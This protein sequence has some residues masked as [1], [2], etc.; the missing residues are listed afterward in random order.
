MS[1]S[2]SIVVC[3]YNSAKRLP[4]TLRHLA[5]Q[6]V[7]ADIP[8][9]VVLIDNASTDDTVE[10]ARRC[11]EPIGPI[12]LRVVSEPLP[13]TGNA[14]FRSFSEARYDIVSF[15]DDDNWVTPDWISKIV[16]FFTSHPDAAVVGGPSIPV[17][18]VPPPA[19]FADIAVS[20]ALGDQHTFSGDITDQPGTLLWTA[21]MNLRTRWLVEL[22]EKDFEFLSCVGPRSADQTR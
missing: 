1:A 20:Y 2:V 5:A 11:W 3:C 7:V 13:G 21:G 17:F 16:E 15:I 18:E 8:W 19:W 22:V 14:R 9:E 6:N 12:P 10:T 4:E